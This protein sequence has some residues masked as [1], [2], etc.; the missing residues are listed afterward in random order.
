MSFCS[1]VQF[2]PPKLNDRANMK[3]AYTDVKRS[4]W[5]SGTSDSLN[6]MIK[7]LKKYIFEWALSTFPFI[8]IDIKWGFN[9]SESSN[10]GHF[11]LTYVQSTEHTLKLGQRKQLNTEQMFFWWFW[12]EKNVINMLCLCWFYDWLMLLYF[13]TIKRRKTYYIDFLTENITNC[14]IVEI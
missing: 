12:E 11:K 7:M 4:I 6:Q 13:R 5:T 10:W 8:L 2:W 9:F 1:V 3:H 14:Q